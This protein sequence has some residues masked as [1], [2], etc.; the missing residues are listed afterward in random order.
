MRLIFIL[1]EKY[2]EL[3]FYNEEFCYKNL[4]QHSESRESVVRYFRRDNLI[5]KVE[6]EHVDLFEI[7]L[8][9]LQI[10][11]EEAQISNN[12]GEAENI[13]KLFTID[14]EDSDRLLNETRL[15]VTYFYGV[16][17][18]QI[19][20]LEEYF[21]SLSAHRKETS[22]SGWVDIKVDGNEIEEIK[23]TI[24]NDVRK[25]LVTRINSTKKRLLDWQKKH[26]REEDL[27]K[28][29]N[30]DLGEPEYVNSN[31]CHVFP[32]SPIIVREDEPTSIIALA[33]SSREYLKEL[34][35][36]RQNV[37]LSITQ[38]APVTPTSEPHQ[39]PQVSNSF[40]SLISSLTSPTLHDTINSGD[41]YMDQYSLSIRR[42]LVKE[43]Q[44]NGIGDKISHGIESLGGMNPFNLS[45]SGKDKKKDPEKDGEKPTSTKSAGKFGAIFGQKNEN[46][47]KPKDENTENEKQEVF[48]EKVPLDKEEKKPQIIVDPEKAAI[49]KDQKQSSKNEKV[50]KQSSNEKNQKQSLNEKDQ[51]QS[52]NE[53]DQKQSS[54]EKDHQKQS[55]NE[56]ELPKKK[57]E[58]II[59]SPA[60]FVKEFS[61]NRKSP[62]DSP[63]LKYQGMHGNKKFSCTIYHATQF[64]SLR[65]RCGIENICIESLSRCDSWKVTGGKSAS[66]FFK[67][68]D[69][70]L[71]V[72]QMVS[73]W[74]TGEKEALLKFAPK[75]FDYMNKPP[76]KPSVL[77]KIF[78]FYTI[79]IKDTKKN[80]VILKMDVLVMEHLFFEKTITRKFDLKGIQERHTKDQTQ[81]NATLWDG[82][83][84]EGRY[85]SLLLIHSHSKK[86]IREAILNDTQFLSDSNIMDYSLLVG[87]DDE[88]KELVV[89]IVDFIGTYTWY[90]KIENRGK[91]IGRNPKEVTVLPPDQYKD[92]FRNSIDQYF[93]AV[94]DK[95]IKS[96]TTDDLSPEEPTPQTPQTPTSPTSPIKSKLPSVL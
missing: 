65:R 43:S 30:I 32:G 45:L 2:L 59:P 57:D 42:K 25:L 84:V 12:L 54:N 80:N 27:E 74:R 94:P 6:Y 91:T 58:T 8:P 70:R 4:C 61:W 87:V 53:K 38:S 79:K 35:L 86:L 68:K 92:R 11:Q 46:P 36:M 33:L 81:D 96:P 89:G 24:L 18:Q 9:K 40:S 5:V 78:G 39:Q 69:E 22:T 60:I 95:W 31:I 20:A 14:A 90:K 63:H 17:K 73:S 71:V 52:L 76:S 16:V 85:K 10:S 23:A 3:L 21:D 28:F 44:G 72:K 50:Q 47:E 19:T 49:E 62:K 77:A 93:S 75:Y 13:D 82:D 7:R 37:R 83:W 64:D 1:L 51:K 29:S 15:E 56:K 34:S 26:V 48:I 55:S 66:T 67:T 88:K 41:D